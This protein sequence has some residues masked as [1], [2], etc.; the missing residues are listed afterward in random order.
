[1][2]VDISNFLYASFFVAQADKDVKTEEERNQY[3]KSLLVGMILNVKSLYKPDEVVLAIDSKNTHRKEGYDHSFK[4]YKA[5]RI[6]KK[7]GSDTDWEAFYRVSNGF[8]DEI[9]A[10]LPVKCVK[11]EKCEADD[12]IA[13][14]T[15]KLRDRKIII[16]SRDKDLSQ[17]LKFPNVSIHNPIDNKLIQCDNP[18]EFLIL[19]LLKGDSGDD[20]PNL[21]SPDNIFVTTGKRQKSITKGIIKEVLEEG[22]D[23]FVIKNNL[24]ANYERNR[25]LIELS[26]EIIPQD[27]QTEIMY[28][29]NN[30][31]VKCD[32]E[33]MMGY[34]ARNNFT[35]LINN[36]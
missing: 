23:K 31:K 2:L 28:E 24:L 12:S 18:H 3:W 13:I 9:K 34:L 10:N 36:L 30:S 16:V 14:L 21:L 1:M 11:V 5:R 8:L 7:E 32:F 20:V 22:L 33:D 17:L 26:E 35:N 4:Y 19:H 25:N 27:L 29:Y 15:S 6:L